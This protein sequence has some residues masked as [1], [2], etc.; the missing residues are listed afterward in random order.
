MRAQPWNTVFLIGFIVYLFI[1]AVFKRRTKGNVVFITR[2]DALEKILIAVVIPGGLLLPLIYLFTPWLAF[3]DYHLPALVHWCGAV[4]MIAALWLF[5][6]SHADLGQNWSVSLEVRQGHELVTQGAY[7]RIRHPMYASIWLWCFAQALLLDNWLAGWY[8]LP[9]FALMY[10]SRVS[11]EEEMMCEF[12]GEQYRAY[13]C[14]TGR[15]FPPLRRGVVR[16]P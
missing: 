7:R 9:T 8:S 2:V 12:F 6:R 1:R 3:A 14:E 10:F 13:A 4:P 15:L 5:Y 16:R 11:R